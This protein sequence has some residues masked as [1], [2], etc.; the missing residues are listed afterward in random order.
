LSSFI[1]Q[2]FLALVRAESSEFVHAYLAEITEVAVRGTLAVNT[3]PDA[4][5]SL[6]QAAKE[7]SA[8][9]LEVLEQTV[10]SAAFIGA[11]SE[12]QRRVQGSKAEKKRQLAAEAITA[13]QKYAARKVK[14][15][16]GSVSP[17][18]RL[19]SPCLCRLPPDRA[20]AEEATGEE[21]PDSKECGYPRPEA[22]NGQ[23]LGCI[24]ILLS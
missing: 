16:H 10:G 2:V 15:K 8:E 5:T 13:P 12:A 19:Y 14:G 4:T 17:G 3:T 7:L 6:V 24:L 11:Y 9:L 21:A 22:E 20:L 23:E 18:L 1:S